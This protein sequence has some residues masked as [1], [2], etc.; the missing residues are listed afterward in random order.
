MRGVVLYSLM[1]ASIL[2][3]PASAQ[4]LLDGASF[5]NM[6]LGGIRL[7]GVSAYSGY[8]TSPYGEAFNQFP[9]YGATGLD[10]NVS[11]GG[12]A[13]LGWQRHS[14]RTDVAVFYS[15]T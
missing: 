10:G 7:Y 4:F 13:S 9:A 3:R 15:G 11:Y 5:K 8:S 2:T 1:A 14:S 12:S 6:S